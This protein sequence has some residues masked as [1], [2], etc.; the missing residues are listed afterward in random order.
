M[1]SKKIP[2]AYDNTEISFFEKVY[3]VARLIPRGRITSYGAI[4]KYLG[5]NAHACQYLGFANIL[6]KDLNTFG[7]HKTGSYGN[8][9][10][11]FSLEYFMQH[12]IKP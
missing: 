1:P 7:Q 3:Q 12:Q 2:S 10:V 9:Y 5:S 11:D 6:E 4:A 8:R